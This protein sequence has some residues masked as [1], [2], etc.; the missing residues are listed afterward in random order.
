MGSPTNLKY[1][2]E[3]EW[4]R[5]ESDGSITVGITDHAQDS[6]GD[7]VFVE[8]PEVGDELANEDKFGVV[9]SVKTVSGLFSPC[10]GEVVAVNES[11]EDEPELVNSSV[12]DDGWMV[13]I[14]PS[15]ASALDELMDAAAYDA[16][17]E[18]E[19]N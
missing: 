8:L 9:E 5:L 4:A 12:Y 10:A 6:L 17:V 15:D 3:H 18:A 19:A 2:K 16:F 1:T 7:V 13:R 11:L 14:Q